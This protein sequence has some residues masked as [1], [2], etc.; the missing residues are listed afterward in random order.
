MGTRDE[1]V[2]KMHE[3]LDRMN[4][5]IDVL[6]SK[7]EQA[8]DEAREEYRKQIAQLRARQND[9]KAKLATLRD[10]GE[11]AWEDL[12]TG[13]EIAKDAIGEAIESARSRFNR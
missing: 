7:A 4:A 2:K 6:A 9:A 13:I 12:K 8:E 11:G 5:E 3:L 1:Y 10:A